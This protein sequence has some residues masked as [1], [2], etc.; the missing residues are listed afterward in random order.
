MNSYGKGIKEGK[1]IE[2]GDLLGYMGNTGYGPEGTMDQFP[3]HLHLGIAYDLNGKDIWINPYP[4]LYLYEMIR[5]ET[6]D[7]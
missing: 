1:K 3:V 4:I 6:L 7:G 5:M 2:A